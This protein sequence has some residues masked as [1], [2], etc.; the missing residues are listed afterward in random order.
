MEEDAI[1]RSERTRRM[2]RIVG[3]L[4]AALLLPPFIVLAIAPMLLLLTP[5]AMVGVPFIIPAL[6]SGS[7]AALRFE[8]RRAGW[9]PMARPRLVFP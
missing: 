4:T 8:R 6:F 5:V 3:S 1:A 9:K 2:L 7:L